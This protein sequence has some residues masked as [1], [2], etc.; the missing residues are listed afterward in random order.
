MAELNPENL[1][2]L[3]YG[4]VSS[5]GQDPESQEHRC[6]QHAQTKGYPVEEVFPDK[7]TGG[8]DFW[9][10]PQ[11]KRLL[12]HIDENP[13]K[14]YVVI[15]DDLKRFARDT[16]FHI[17]LRKEFKSRDVK[18]ECL[19]YNFED[20]P[21]GE[22]V[23]TMFAAQGQ[24]ERQQNRRQVI[25]K[26]K[27]RLERGY[28]SFDA[29]PGLKYI[30]DPVHGK[31]LIADEPKASIIKKA[32]EGFADNTFPNQVDVQAFLE[33]R[34]FFHRKKHKKV[35]LEQVKRILTRILYTPFIEYPD[36]GITRRKGYHQAF[37]S[38]ETFEK[39]QD[40]LS[41]TA[42]TVARKDVHLDFPARGFVLCS[43]CGKPYTASW[44]TK[45]KGYRKPYY[46]CN[47]PGC[48]E[49]NKSIPR[50][51]IEGGLGEILKKIRP[52]KEVLDLTKEVALDIWN[53]RTLDTKQAE[54]EIEKEITN[55]NVETERIV[56]RITKTD[57]EVVIG[58][59]EK[60]IE[61]L[62]NKKLLFEERK[63]KPNLYSG[64]D[65]E[66]ALDE[67]FGYIEN[68]YK[69]WANGI[70]EDKRLVLRMVF[71]EHL[72]YNKKSGFETAS[73][74]LPITLFQQSANSNS[75]LVDPGRIELPPPQCE[76]GVIPLYYGPVASTRRMDN[77]I[78]QSKFQPNSTSASTA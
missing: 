42:K 47:K 72:V 58:A 71:T 9:K 22:F 38:L 78:Q 50:E 56:E 24:L 12:N 64:V 74:S 35:N 70:F 46:R 36:W 10:R 63:G 52:Y 65:F 77:T 45:R 66:T 44:T 31:I 62:T 48:I 61:E 49:K 3:I 2:A 73:F 30:K 37:I 6:R 11:L 21:E 57:N 17:R 51:N 39:I 67:V 25:Q 59:Y 40:K 60:K 34:N 1:I 76:C 43:V 54:M 16:E 19:N 28:W 14:K 26:M 8:G 4:R 53:E 7:F 15:F 13:H 55:I 68:P 18:I 69:M 23:E 20:S 27:A 41:G 33:S 29:P 32:L 5:M 75:L